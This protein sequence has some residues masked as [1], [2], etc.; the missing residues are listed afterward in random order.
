MQSQIELAEHNLKGLE[1]KDHELKT[2]YAVTKDSVN[3]WSE[4]WVNMKLNWI[5]QDE[6]NKKLENLNDDFE[7]IMSIQRS[8]IQI[9]DRNNNLINSVNHDITITRHENKELK[10][11]LNSFKGNENSAKKQLK[12]DNKMFKETM[13]MNLLYF[14]SIMSMIIITLKKVYGK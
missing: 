8:L 6:Y 14:F 13:F 1:D 3:I 11:R 2:L 5:S 4:A 9:R 12:M 7:K 10:H